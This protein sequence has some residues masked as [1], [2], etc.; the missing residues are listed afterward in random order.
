MVISR[1]ANRII[2][3]AIIILAAITAVIISLFVNF[4]SGSSQPAGNNYA[5]RLQNETEDASDA[6]NIGVSGTENLIGLIGEDYARN[7]G[8]TN[9]FIRWCSAERYIGEGGDFAGDMLSHVLSEGYSDNL[10]YS[11]TGNTLKALLADYD[12][13]NGGTAR[14]IET[15]GSLNMVFAGGVD[16][17]YDNP[18][19]EHYFVQENGIASCIGGELLSIVKNADIFMLSAKYALTDNI[20]AA[21]ESGIFTAPADEACALSDMGADIVSISN[22]NAASGGEDALTDTVEALADEGITA[23]GMAG[24]KGTNPAPLY[25]TAGGMKIGIISCTFEADIFKD[26]DGISP[27]FSS[28][29]DLEAAV[30]NA[31]SAADYLIVY[32]SRAEAL[33][34]AEQT[35]IEG[36][37]QAGADLIVGENVNY[38]S[39]TSQSEGAYIFNSLS[40]FWCDMGTAPTAVLSLKLT[41]GADGKPSAAIEIIPCY[42]RWGT[43]SSVTGADA[44]AV[45]DIIEN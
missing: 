36:L 16:L 31:K 39:G 3:I 24:D 45:M 37:A 7:S 17:S 30:R 43:V 44:E 20:P 2:V 22:K 27:V 42:Q 35:A 28:D 4:S 5:D 11:L 41:L 40:K 34:E 15:D 23:I 14:H 12:R 32:V 19:S 1:T 18:L 21:R 8:I 33:T 10:W 38:L 25:Y 29:Y 9:E 6:Q 26:E 13:A